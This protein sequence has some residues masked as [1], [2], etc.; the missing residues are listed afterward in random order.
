MGPRLPARP[1]IDMLIIQSTPFCNIDCAYCYLPN[2]SSKQRMSETTLVRT[3][4]RV[5][6]SA[7]LSDA[8]TVLWHA[9][10]P[11]S[12]GM[13]YYE[14]AFDLLN[15]IK[16]SRLSIRHSFQTNGILVT[17]SWIDFFKAHNV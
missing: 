9:G 3:F 4:E 14:R 13:A 17:Q 10:E 11:L 12:A 5:F 7:F 1:V 6:T 2:R 15:Q 16:P 8:L